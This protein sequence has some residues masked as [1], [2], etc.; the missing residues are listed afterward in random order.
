MTMILLVKGSYICTR[1]NGC[2]HLFVGI[3]VGIFFV[4]K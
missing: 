2:I 4:Q 1:S 3:D